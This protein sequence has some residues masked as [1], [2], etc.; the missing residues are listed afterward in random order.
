MAIMSHLL[1]F[2]PAAERLVI[3]DD[4][5]HKFEVIPN[6]GVLD[7]WLQRI[8]F[9]LDPNLP[10]TEKLARIAAGDYQTNIIWKSSWLKEDLR[11]IVA[12]TSIVDRPRIEEMPALIMPQEVAL[13]TFPDY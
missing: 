12:I 4:I 8:T 5:R 7:I 10:F 13:F 1:D 3:V 6:T 9:K 11:T 2:C